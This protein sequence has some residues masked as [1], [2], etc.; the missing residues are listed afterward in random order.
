MAA[1]GFILCS[2]KDFS[3]SS[4]EEYGSESEY[5]IDDCQFLADFFEA[6]FIDLA[7][8]EI[9]ESV[10]CDFVPFAVSDR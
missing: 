1:C 7:V 5:M 4:I 8:C 3:C 10:G 9:L 2:S 6:H